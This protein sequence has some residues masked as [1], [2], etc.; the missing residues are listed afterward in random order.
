MIPK[1]VVF[2][3]DGTVLN[4][5]KE[6]SKRNIEAI[7]RLQSKNIHTVFA[8]ARPPRVTSFKGFDAL[9]RDG[10]MVYYNG[11]YFKCTK[12]LDDCH[13][14]IEPAVAAKVIDFIEELDHD[15]VVTVE[16]KDSLYGYKDIDYAV[17]DFMKKDYYPEIVDMEFLKSQELTKILIADF[18]YSKEL[19][20]E[21]SE[22][23]NIIV[24]D[25]GRLVQVMSSRV[26]K[27]IA[28]AAIAGNLGITMKDVICFGD[29]Y[30]DLELFRAVGYSVAMG[31]A[32]H[33][34]KEIASEV[35]LTNDED[36]VA[37]VLERILDEMDDEAVF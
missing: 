14:G 31:N 35:T 23:L 9:S 18:D 15:A 37:A 36:G 13:F 32:V 20:E 5:N 21:F 22:E 33:D 4:S 27:E 24:T 28:I 6:I 34:L 8:T 2:D 30:N 11:A 29:D 16:I 26:G 3:L 25:A 19:A 1:A 7:S 17:L 10:Y 12:T